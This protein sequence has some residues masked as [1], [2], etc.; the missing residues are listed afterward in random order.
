MNILLNSR[1]YFDRHQSL[2][3]EVLAIAAAIAMLA[4]VAASSLA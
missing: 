2:V 1:R 3:F 4:A